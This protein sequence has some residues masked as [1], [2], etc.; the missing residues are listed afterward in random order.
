MNNK[1]L[2]KNKVFIFIYFLDITNLNIT[3]YVNNKYKVYL[4]YHFKLIHS[5]F[6]KRKFYLS[7]IHKQ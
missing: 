5:L 4:G 3:L 2:S 1:S 7:Y 6:Y